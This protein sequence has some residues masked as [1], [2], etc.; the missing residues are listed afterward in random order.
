MCPPADPVA[1]RILEE[2][3]AVFVANKKVLPPPVCVF[4]TEDQVTKFQEDAGYEGELI[5]FDRSNSNQR[6]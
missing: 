4:T 3:G 5:G 1:R 6:R 2:Y